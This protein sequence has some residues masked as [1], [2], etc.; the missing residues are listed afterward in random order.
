MRHTKFL[1]KKFQAKISLAVEV[2][3]EEWFTYYT[4]FL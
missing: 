4:I 3:E 1:L 2:L